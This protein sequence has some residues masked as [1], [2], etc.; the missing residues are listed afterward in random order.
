MPRYH[1]RF[2]DLRA[3]LT[4]WDPDAAAHAAL[5]L[6]QTS[7]N[8]VFSRGDSVLVW[9]LPEN[10]VDEEA[11]ELSPYDLTDL[12]GVDKVTELGVW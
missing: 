3:T 8:G 10:L 6:W 5:D 11:A 4:A 12:C 9:C 2:A 7:A 1:V